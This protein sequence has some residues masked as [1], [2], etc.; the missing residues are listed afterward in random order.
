ML[1]NFYIDGFNL[2]KG[3]LEGGPHKWLNLVEF[4]RRRL[5]IQGQRLLH[6]DYI[7]FDSLLNP[8]ALT[9]G[10]GRRFATYKRAPLIFQQM[11]NIVQLTRDKSLTQER[12]DALSAAMKQVEDA[13]GAARNAA[14][15]RLE[16]LAAD[17]TK[18][19]AT[20]NPLAAKRMKAAV[21]VI[22]KRSAELK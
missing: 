6:G 3:C 18:D 15:T 12:A 1:T 10:F 2:Y 11:E 14:K 19:A 5:L 16:S 7:V 21:A 22:Q 13:S 20:A 4:C 8:D 17:L 9:I